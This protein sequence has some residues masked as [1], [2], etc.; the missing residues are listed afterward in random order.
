LA[1]IDLDGTG[2][3]YV[4]LHWTMECGNDYLNKTIQ[5]T[6]NHTPEPATLLLFG[7]GLLGAGAYG[8]RRF[9]IEDK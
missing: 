7:M 4:T 9:K 2:S 1:D 8:R 5:Y 3:Y 6:P